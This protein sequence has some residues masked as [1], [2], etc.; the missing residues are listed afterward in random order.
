MKRLLQMKRLLLVAALLVGIQACD[1]GV[2]GP[3]DAP[4]VLN[5]TVTSEQGADIGAVLLAVDGPVESV[6]KGVGGRALSRAETDRVVVAVVSSP[7]KPTVRFE[8]SIPAGPTPAVEIL[9]AADG[10]NEL[11]EDASAFTVDFV[12]AESAP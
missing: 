10:D 12:D 3:S 9:Q 6:R 11:Y 5:V 4:R 8:M 2:S 1:D 7:A